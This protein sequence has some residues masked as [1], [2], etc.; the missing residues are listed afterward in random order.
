[1][2]LLTT[3]PEAL[4]PWEALRSQPGS[5]T[6]VQVGGLPWLGPRRAS[7]ARA[8]TLLSVTRVGPK[9]GVV[10]GL[11]LQGAPLPLLSP[12][13]KTTPRRSWK[14][15]HPHQNSHCLGKGW[16]QGYST[17]SK[18]PTHGLDNEANLPNLMV[19]CKVSL[20]PHMALP[21]PSVLL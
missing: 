18:I 8:T 11:L 7:E 10:G 15:L 19:L 21:N 2:S 4:C 20:C 14:E 3:G 6:P 5:H 1:M 9:N 17:P 12:V 16:R 13:R